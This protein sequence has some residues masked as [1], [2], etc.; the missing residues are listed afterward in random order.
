VGLTKAACPPAKVHV[1]NATLRRAYRECD[2]WRERTLERITQKEHPSLIVTSSLPTYRPR[3]DGKRLPKEADREAL[4][5]GYASTLKKLRSTGAPVALIEEVP[6][7]NKNVP[8][9][10]SRSLVHLRECASPRSKALSYP[11][12]NDRAAEEV[13]GVRLIDPTPMICLKKMCPAVIGDALVYR[14]GSHLTAAYVRTFTPW[15]ANHLPEPH[16]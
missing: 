16:R 9:C 14:N 5:E 3:M 8:Q 10:V 12:V 15:L 2:E 6:H 1:Y 13:E 7:P 4:V 11:K